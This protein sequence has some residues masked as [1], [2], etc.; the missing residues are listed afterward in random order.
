MLKK[1][2]YGAG[3]WA[4]MF[5]GVSALMVTPIP[6]IWQKILEIVLAGVGALI[7]GL[8]YFKKAPG[9]IKNGLTLGVIWFIVGGILDLLITIQY[10]KAGGSYLFGLKTFYGAWSL[11]A[12]FLAMFLGL[13]MAAKLK[14]SKSGFPPTLESPQTP[15]PPPA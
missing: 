15:P 3:F 9:T 4:I 5:I 7:L 14:G 1:I 2:G 6:E 10:V 12:G 13:I 8:V 11:W